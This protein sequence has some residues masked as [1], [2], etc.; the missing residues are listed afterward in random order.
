MTRPY[1]D[2]LRERAMARV[3]AGETIRAIGA[4][5]KVSPSCVSKWCSRVRATGSVSPA[6]IGGYKP[7]VLSGDSARWLDARMRDRPFTLRGLVTELSERGVK[8]DYRSVWRFA[9][10]AGLSFKKNR[11]RQRARAS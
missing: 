1:S 5:L 3:A 10:D 4:A 9:H 2:D 8:V 7:R 6:Q 11:A